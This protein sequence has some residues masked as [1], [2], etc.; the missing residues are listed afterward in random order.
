MSGAALGIFGTALLTSDAL[1]LGA[2]FGPTWGIFAS[3]GTPVLQADS[4]ASMRYARDYNVSSYP[5]EQ[6][7]FESYNKVQV[8]F[9]AVVRFICANSRYE[10]LQSVEAAAAAL[11]L[12]SIYTPEVNYPSANIVHYNFQRTVKQ[13]VTLVLVDVW[14]T[15]IRVTAG[16]QVSQTSSTGTNANTNNVAGGAGTAAINNVA[17]NTNT[18][19]PVVGTPSSDGS[20]TVQ[21]NNAAFPSSTGYTQAINLQTIAYPS[22]TAL[23]SLP[24]V[25]AASQSSLAGSGFSTGLPVPQ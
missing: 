4:V 11:S 14:C 18:S 9:Q 24:P 16:T 2:L 7:A 3:D 21:S 23:S 12:V 13:G 5:Q 1:G 17:S 6:G 10:F 19:L 25:D 20:P 15:E 22:G 8:P